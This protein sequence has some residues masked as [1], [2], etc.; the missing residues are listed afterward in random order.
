MAIDNRSRE[1]LVAENRELRFRLEEAEETL[2]AIQSGAVDAIVVFAPEGEQIF[3]LKGADHSYR[4]LVETMTEGAATMATDGTILYC[5]RHLATMLH[6][7]LEKLFG[8]TFSS[9]V[10]PAD[11]P[12]L[13]SCL[14]RCTDD[15]DKDEITLIT[16]QGNRIPVLFSC[17]SV[18]LSGTRGVGVVLTDISAQKSMEE[19]LRTL[20][21]EL[22][23]RVTERTAELVTK[24]TELEKM[25][26]IFVGRELRM[27]ELKKQIKDLESHSR[28]VVD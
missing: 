6:V 14:G 10:L 2:Q 8:S 17:C 24:N 22:E 16:D 1:E 9:Y 28:A 19:E 11:L 13:A 15:L 20:N 3:T 7:P 4:V 12:R 5:N 21:E 23:Q 26:R 25:N 27:A 18:D